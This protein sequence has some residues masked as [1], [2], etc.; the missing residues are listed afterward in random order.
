MYV[1]TL[2]RSLQMRE[3]R[4][5]TEWQYTSESVNFGIDSLRMYCCCCSV[6][7]FVVCWG[8]GEYTGNRWE[9]IRPHPSLPF[10][11]CCLPNSLDRF[12]SCFFCLKTASQAIL[13]FLVLFPVRIS[14]LNA[15]PVDQLPCHAPT[16]PLFR[17]SLMSTVFFL[18]LPTPAD[19]LSEENF[20]LAPTSKLAY[21]FP[22]FFFRRGGDALLHVKSL[23]IINMPRVIDRVSFPP[24]RHDVHRW[25]CKGTHPTLWRQI[26]LK[27]YLSLSACRGDRRMK[28]KVKKTFCLWAVHW[29]GEMERRGVTYL[30]YTVGYYPPT[31]T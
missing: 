22:H 12:K 16:S 15:H 1:L 14:M 21:L 30:L 26:C 9:L 13:V 17:S 7:L 10:W 4:H 23:C 29:R 3:E 20:S 25:G 31:H 11:A 28:K 18:G 5:S 6:C 2:P 24:W 27:P 8:G 19:T